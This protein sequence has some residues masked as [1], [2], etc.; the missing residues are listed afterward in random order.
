ATA[1]RLT[2]DGTFPLDTRYLLTV[3]RYGGNGFRVWKNGSEVTDGSPNDGSVVTITRA[4]GT[5]AWPYE[6]SFGFFAFADQAHEDS[7]RSAIQ[8]YVLGRYEVD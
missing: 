7:S 1:L 2:A 8:S 6:G 4:I 3:I 5:G